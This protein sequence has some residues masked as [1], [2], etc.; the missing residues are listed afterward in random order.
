[1]R[2]RRIIRRVAH[3]VGG[4]VALWFTRQV[5]FGPAVSSITSG[6]VIAFNVCFYRA[7][8]CLEPIPPRLLQGVPSPPPIKT[9]GASGTPEGLFECPPS[10]NSRM[11][12]YM[13]STYQK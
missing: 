9:W 7:F 4:I 11:K 12:F 3:I 5:R 13:Q 2:S 10:I 8:R 1:M 6:C